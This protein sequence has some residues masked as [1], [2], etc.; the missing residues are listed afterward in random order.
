M[1]K[2]LAVKKVLENQNL[3]IYI[4]I[5]A[6]IKLVHS[7]FIN[8][9]Q[10]KALRLISSQ[11]HRSLFHHSHSIVIVHFRDALIAVFDHEFKSIFVE[12]FQ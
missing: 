1:N 7:C 5:D 2:N 9:K 8:N 12:F 4:T 10:L 3:L 6:L 11:Y